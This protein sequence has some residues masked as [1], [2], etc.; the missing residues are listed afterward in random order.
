MVHAAADEG[1]LTHAPDPAQATALHRAV[2][3][4]ARAL[5]H[6]HFDGDGC[7]EPDRQ[8]LRL[9]GA[10]IIT[11]GHTTGTRNAYDAGCRR[12]GVA[13]RDDGLGA[14]AHPGRP[15]RAHIAAVLAGWVGPITFSPGH[16]AK[17]GLGGR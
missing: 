14:V 9:G 17:A 1:W 16:T 4:L 6:R 10:A 11:P 13:A 12:L 7:L 15:R 3:D 8:V 2:N 5:A